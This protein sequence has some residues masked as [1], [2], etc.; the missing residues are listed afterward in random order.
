MRALLVAALLAAP[1]RGQGSPSY[2]PPV[3]P[4]AVKRG[5]IVD[6]SFRRGGVSL[7]SEGW[8]LATADIGQSVLVMR[9]GGLK[10]VRGTV[11]GPGLVEMGASR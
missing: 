10:A 6:L 11:R 5:D 9:D 7:A 1:V 3:A 2:P 4:P 8:A